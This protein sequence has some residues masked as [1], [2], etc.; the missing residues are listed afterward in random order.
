MDRFSVLLLKVFITTFF[1]GCARVQTLNL[2]SHKYSERPKHI[3]WIQIAGFSE[4]HIPLLR[5]ANSAVNYK[6][7]FEQ[8]DCSGKMWNFNLYKLR[9]RAS[10]S[11]LSQ[12][13]GSK[14]IKETCED[15][16][17][18]PVWAYLDE[19]DYVS[20][21][22]E[23]GASLDQSLEKALSC[24]TNK[25]VNLDKLHF[26]KMGK[27]ITGKSKIFH[28]QD[29]PAQMSSFQQ[30]GL[31]YDRSCQRGVCYSSLAENFKTLSDL[32][33][34]ERKNTFFLVRDFN[35]QN[36]LKKKNINLAKEILQDLENLL[37]FVKKK[38]MDDLLVVISG[39]ESQLIE[40]PLQGKDWA[41]YEKTGSNIFYKQSSLMSPVLASGAM[42]ENFCGIFDESE[43]L[44]RM[45]YKPENKVFNFDLLNPF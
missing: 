15:Y 22:L 41:N 3:V 20:G 30:A 27:D 36:A 12:I 35:F 44:K 26:W 4:E 43:M 24:S 5:F 11:F 2:S 13:N 21:I 23:S 6:T 34:K 31:Y 7:N 14:N 9:P 39:A 45:L 29:T 38:K 10:E 18:L 19:L 8:I 17:N 16:E 28:F 25:T 42:S 33:L 1:W 37:S 40:F 32:L